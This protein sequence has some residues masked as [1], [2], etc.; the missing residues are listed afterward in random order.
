MTRLITRIT[1]RL[2]RRLLLTDAFER[3]AGTWSVA[4]D[5]DQIEATEVL[6]IVLDGPLRRRRS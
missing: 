4:D 3:P 2:R 5:I 6:Q 1:R